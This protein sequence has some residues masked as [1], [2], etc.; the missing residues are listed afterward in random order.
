MSLHFIKRQAKQAGKVL[1]VFLADHAAPFTHSQ[2]LELVAQLHGFPNYHA[3]E[4][5]VPKSTSS[6]RATDA[7]APQSENTG[8]VSGPWWCDTCGERITDVDAGYLI[9][10]T[11]NLRH[12]H[13]FRIIHQSRCDPRGAYTS[14]IPLKDVVGGRGLAKLLSFLAVGPV[15]A[16]SEST[17]HRIRHMEEFVDLVRRVQTPGYER[18]R[19][20]F[21]DPT[22]K[23]RMRDWNE[24]S[25]YVPDELTD[26]LKWPISELQDHVTHETLSNIDYAGIATVAWPD[27]VQKTP[28]RGKFSPTALE[29]ALEATGE[30]LRFAYCADERFR[31]QLFSDDGTTEGNVMLGVESVRG[32]QC[33]LVGTWS[34]G[35]GDAPFV[36]EIDYVDQ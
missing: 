9:F 12:S 2:C 25:P 23:E 31:A 11:D 34:E 10:R 20:H 36:V 5:A 22:W 35:D 8:V 33:R 29:L 15:L 4:T 14:S 7:D 3:A 30:T 1:P 32:T 27:D 17:N 21:S 28:V 6:A 16:K 24:Y 26:M 18:A 13:D 19:R